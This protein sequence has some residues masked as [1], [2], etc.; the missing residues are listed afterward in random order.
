MFDN[1]R[2][3]IDILIL[4]LSP[5]LKV[6]LG[7]DPLFVPCFLETSVVPECYQIYLICMNISDREWY[8]LEPSEVPLLHKQKTKGQFKPKAECAR[9]PRHRFSRKTN[10]WHLTYVR[11]GI[12]GCGV[13]K[14]GIQNK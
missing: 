3:I 9:P 14:A 8:H 12:S 7:K 4:I 5:V 11:Y 1:Q 13:F 6:E 2:L 10:E